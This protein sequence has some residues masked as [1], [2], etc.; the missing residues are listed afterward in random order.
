MPRE[1]LQDTQT[2]LYFSTSNAK[3][4]QLIQY[5]REKGI[6]QTAAMRQALTEFLERE[7][8]KK[9]RAEA[10]KAAKSASS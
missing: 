1:K 2:W 9:A 7:A 5:A 4:D 10:K 6:T 8:A 3:R